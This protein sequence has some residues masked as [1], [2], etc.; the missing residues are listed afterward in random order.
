MSGELYD[1]EA[2]D[3][4]SANKLAIEKIVGHINRFGNCVMTPAARKFIIGFEIHIKGKSKQVGHAWCDALPKERSSTGASMSTTESQKETYRFE[5]T[6][7]L[8]TPHTLN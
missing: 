5:N 1:C 8:I 2:L 7:E 6:D 3:F 4:K